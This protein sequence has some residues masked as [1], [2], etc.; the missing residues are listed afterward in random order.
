MAGGGAE[1]GLAIRTRER[2]SDTAVSIAVVT[3]SGEHHE[4]RMAF[5]GGRNG[6]SRAALLAA[7]ALFRVLRDA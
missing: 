2:G 6:R 1:V 7:A 5:L 4:R 3:P